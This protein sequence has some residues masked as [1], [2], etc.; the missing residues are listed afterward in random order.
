[1]FREEPPPCGPRGVGLW[2]AECISWGSADEAE[3][4]PPERVRYSGGTTS[5]WSA[6]VGYA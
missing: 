1:M 2:M 6:L 3:L 4:V 5:V